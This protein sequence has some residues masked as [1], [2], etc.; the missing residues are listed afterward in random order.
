MDLNLFLNKNS[1]SST[2]LALLSTTFAFSQKQSKPNILVIMTD[3][4]SAESMSSVLGNKY[5]NTPN[6]D[7]LAQ[8]GV[9]F[10]NAYC[11]NPLSIP[12]RSSMFTGRYPHEID[13]Q[14][15]DFK[16]IDT[17]KYPSIG[18]KFKDSGYETAYFGKWHLPFDL[19]NPDSHGFD[20]LAFNKSNGVDDKLAG[21]AIEYM[22]LKSSKP[23]MM[24]VS[25]I[26]PHN[27]CEWARS[28]KLPDGEIG[29]PPPVNDC[30]PLRKNALASTNETDIM[31]TMRKSYQSNRLFPVGD[32]DET[33][34]REYSW[35]Y[36][37]LIEKVDTEIGKILNSL[38]DLGLDQNTYIVFMSDHGD[39]QGAHQ[40]NQKTVFYEESAK[41]P[42]IISHPGL[43]VG[44]SDVLVQ[45]GIDFFPSL[46]D[47]AEIDISENIKGI[48]LKPLL[49][50]EKAKAD[51]IY[52]VVSNKM[53]QGE[54][55]NGVKIEPEGRMLRTG[56]FKYWI[57][58]E[59][60]QS[61]ILYDL[62]NDPGE[63]VNLA[64]NPKYKSTMDN[65]RKE[66]I[67]WAKENKDPYLQ[68]LIK[69]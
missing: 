19:N 68:Y 14:T 56:H 60:D 59:G 40:W 8:H 49:K 21:S 45:T 10:T 15:N 32:F 18:T 39:C 3:Q 33:K 30:P 69:K 63:M 46:C 62:K 7:Y 35:A 9:V 52:I 38:R 16:F 26:N 47:L 11:A 17:K 23:F 57:Y 43:E 37:R 6:M 67:K 54:A 27:I 20:S 29:T 55:I 66:L 61:E 5:L 50:N 1:V 28:N 22:K 53:V 2:V 42:L 48:S 41:V 51:R 58:S 12:S 65:C 4:Q 13:I 25:F 31:R 34:W 64:S 44:K 24:V 36:Y